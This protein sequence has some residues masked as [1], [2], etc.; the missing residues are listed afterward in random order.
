VQDPIKPAEN[1]SFQPC[2][3]TIDANLEIGVA[4]SGV[5]GPLIVGSSCDRSYVESL[6]FGA[7]RYGR[8]S[9]QSQCVRRIRRRDQHSGNHSEQPHQQLGLQEPDQ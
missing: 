1:S 8:L 7:V 6:S 9:L 4:K 3:E 2:S 5:K